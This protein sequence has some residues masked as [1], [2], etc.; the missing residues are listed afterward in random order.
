MQPYNPQSFIKLHLLLAAITLGVTL[1]KWPVML[2]WG[3]PFIIGFAIYI[4]LI[5]AVLHAQSKKTK[6]GYLFIIFILTEIYLAQLCVNA[7]AEVWGR[8][9][10]L[11][12]FITMCLIVTI[13]FACIHIYILYS[14]LK[15][16][17]QT[18]ISS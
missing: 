4:G 3:L 9:Q 10:H 7:L 5:A 14:S 1:V 17:S 12:S 2:F 15:L 18:S 6:I 16:K 13:L 11:D 8:A